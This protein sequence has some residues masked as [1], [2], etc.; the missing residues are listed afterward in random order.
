MDQGLAGD[1]Y[2]KGRSEEFEH[3]AGVAAPN[4]R[5]LQ[6]L[7]YQREVRDLIA[8]LQTAMP[9]LLPWVEAYVIG[10]VHPEYA[11]ERMDRALEHIFERV[12]DATPRRAASELMYY[13]RIKQ[14]Y[15][16][17]VQIRAEIVK[18]RLYKRKQRAEMAQMKDE[19]CPDEPTL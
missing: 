12:P 7:E 18:M 13:K 5:G 11:V 6:K 1:R 4:L 19:S 15:K 14:K 3:T 2:A 8:K 10:V 17:F 16:K 9:S